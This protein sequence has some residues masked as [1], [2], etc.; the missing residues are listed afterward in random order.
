MEPL[1]NF[2]SYCKLAAVIYHD[3]SCEMSIAK[4]ILANQSVMIAVSNTNTIED[5]LEYRAKLAVYE[6]LEELFASRSYSLQQI[7]DNP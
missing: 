7:G 3:I 4:S 2:P 6:A 5:A 1:E